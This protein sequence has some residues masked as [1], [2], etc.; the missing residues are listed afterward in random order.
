MMELILDFLMGSALLGMVWGFY[1][2]IFGGR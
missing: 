2:V 1:L